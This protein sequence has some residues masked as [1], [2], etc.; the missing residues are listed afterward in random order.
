MVVWSHAGIF[1]AQET[2]DKLG[3]NPSRV[4]YKSEEMGNQIYPDIA[5]DD[6]DLRIA[7]TMIRV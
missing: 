7:K 3:L 6:L 4:L 1:H 2:A 5:V